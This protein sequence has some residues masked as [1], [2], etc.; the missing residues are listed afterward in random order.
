[1]T[2][3]PKTPHRKC[4]AHTVDVCLTIFGELYTNNNVKSSINTITDRNKAKRQFSLHLSRNAVL[5]LMHKL[6]T[7]CETML[8]FHAV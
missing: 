3:M 4:F 6:V 2:A 1:M 8:M 5:T 7:H